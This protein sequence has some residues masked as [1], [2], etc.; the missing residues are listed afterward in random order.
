MFL[1]FL[2]NALEIS[3][4]EKRHRCNEMVELCFTDYPRI[5][6]AHPG[7]QGITFTTKPKCTLAAFK[8]E[9]VA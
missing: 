7:L 4:E 8:R 1:L 3:R 2:F 5:W 6:V 9:N